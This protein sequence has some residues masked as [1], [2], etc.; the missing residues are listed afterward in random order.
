M[1]EE[2]SYR[3]LQADFKESVPTLNLL[4]EPTVAEA[5][6]I[7]RSNVGKSSLIN[8][9]CG[10]KSLAKTSK[11]PGRTQAFNYYSITFAEQDTSS[12]SD[13]RKQAYFVDL[14]GYGYAKVSKRQQDKWPQMIEQ[15]LLRRET[16][17]LLV[18]LV[19]CRRAV[20][21]EERWL[22]ELGRGGALLVAMTKADKLSGNGLKKAQN[23]IAEGL[24]IKP[25]R[26]IATSTTK[27]RGI[28][29][30][31]QLALRSLASE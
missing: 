2:R 28:G 30:L 17:K 4:R 16:L 7:G 20:E 9:I 13:E 24:G 27:K 12:E 21:E 14:P 31:Q 10:R 22:A 1:S 18:L 5:A 6:F 11:M 3:I 26:I 25:D 29:E 23:E 15:Y 8:A 19:D